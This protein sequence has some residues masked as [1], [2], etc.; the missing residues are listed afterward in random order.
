M[1]LT[2][3]P[4]LRGGGGGCVDLYRTIVGRFLSLSV[5]FSSEKCLL[6]VSADFK[7]FAVIIFLPQLKLCED[8]G[9]F[10]V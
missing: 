6:P 3:P 8:V 4:A 9:S 2:C 1:D 7:E 10:T 5:V